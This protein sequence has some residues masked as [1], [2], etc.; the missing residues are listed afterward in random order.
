M[1][2]FKDSGFYKNYLAGDDAEAKD[3]AE[4]YARHA[5]ICQTFLSSLPESKAGYRY[6]EGKWSVREVV[7]HITDAD[8]I[9]LYRLVCIARG[10]RQP[11]P[12]F[13]ENDYAEASVYDSLSWRAVLDAWKGVS[14]AVRGLI[15]GIDSVGWE[16]VGT[17]AGVQL[18]S[19]DMLRVLI[20]HERHHMRVLKELYGLG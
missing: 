7:G 10:E 16:R 5:E 4:A 15:A 12:S 8:L 20:G 17:A 18:R 9:F 13:E 6:A 19:S 11:L 1:T 14:Q 3:P 2:A